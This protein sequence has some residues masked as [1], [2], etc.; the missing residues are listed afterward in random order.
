[1]CAKVCSTIII[2]SALAV[3][4][5]NTWGQSVIAVGPNVQVSRTR[6]DWEHNEVILAADPND[7]R[8]LLAGS[9]FLDPSKGGY[10]VVT[11]VSFDS[12]RSWTPSLVVGRDRGHYGDPAIAFGC[13]GIAYSVSLKSVGRRSQ[14]QTLVHRSDDGGKT[15]LPPTVLPYIDRE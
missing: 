6:P 4:V 10:S 11:Y 8:H 9:M 12:G 3:W 7:A 15:W 2:V 1:M 13:S 5:S 14:W